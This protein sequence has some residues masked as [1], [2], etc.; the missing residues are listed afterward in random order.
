MFRVDFILSKFFFEFWKKRDPDIMTEINEYYA[1]YIKRIEEVNQRFSTRFWKGVKTERGRVYLLYGKPDEIERH[2][3]EGNSK[4]YHIWYYHSLEGGCRFIFADITG[5]KN[6]EL[7]HS[8]KN[9]EYNDP[10]WEARVV[11]VRD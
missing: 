1:E 5:F 11:Q 8:T 6:F 10:T 2:T 9:G 4:P 7:V 3:F